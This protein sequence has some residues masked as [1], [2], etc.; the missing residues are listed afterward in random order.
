MTKEYTGLLKDIA[1]EDLN[2][3]IIEKRIVFS[4][5]KHNWPG[6]VVR[7]FTLKAGEENAL[8]YHDWPHWG[9]VLKGS[10]KSY[11]DGEVFKMEE[12][13]WFYV[14]PKVHHKFEADPGEDLHFICMVPEEGDITPVTLVN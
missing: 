7:Y 1:L 2:S 6:H 9:L 3:P 10:G 13:G 12:Q 4:P 14:P 5:D 8:H 11:V